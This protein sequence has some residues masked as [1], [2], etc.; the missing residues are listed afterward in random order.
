MTQFDVRIENKAD[1]DAWNEVYWGGG[2]PIQ[3]SMEDLIF[4]TR[5]SAN[6]LGF[7]DDGEYSHSITLDAKAYRLLK[8]RFNHG[9]NRYGKRERHST[10]YARRIRIHAQ[11]TQHRYRR[12]AKW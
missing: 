11:R 9:K 3:I 5:A 6:C 7:T 2:N 8:G 10:R 12:S 4:L 1:L